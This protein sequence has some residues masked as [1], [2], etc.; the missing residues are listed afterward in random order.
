MSHVLRPC[1]SRQG[2]GIPR[3]SRLFSTRATSHPALIPHEAGGT[4]GSLPAIPATPESESPAHGGN[5]R[6]FP[7][8]AEAP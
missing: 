2:L 8:G 6:L 3:R 7:L 5:P 1:D 4:S